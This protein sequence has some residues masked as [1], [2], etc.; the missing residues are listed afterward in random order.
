M[1]K[2]FTDCFYICPCR[3]G[4]AC[5]SVS[6]HVRA[7]IFYLLGSSFFSFFVQ[8]NYDPFYQ[9]QERR[10]VPDISN[11]IMKDKTS[12]I[13]SDTACIIHARKFHI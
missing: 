6:G 1:P 3:I 11:R 9:R 7:K 4:K 13:P 5:V 2:N 10:F 8:T 12:H